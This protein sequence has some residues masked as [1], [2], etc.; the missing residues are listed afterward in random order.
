MSGVANWRQSARRFGWSLG[1]Y[2]PGG[3]EGGLPYD[4]F[5]FGAELSLGTCC[6]I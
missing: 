3:G 4:E 2:L 5:H 1:T 6:R